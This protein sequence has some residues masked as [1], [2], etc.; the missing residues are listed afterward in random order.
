M[1]IQTRNFPTFTWPKNTVFLTLAWN[2]KKYDMLRYIF[3][4]PILF[5]A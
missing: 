4:C 1:M 5:W 2:H 3:Q